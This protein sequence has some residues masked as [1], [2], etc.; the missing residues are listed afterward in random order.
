[1]GVD[2][3]LRL[4][5]PEGKAPPNQ[6]VLE[7]VGRFDVFPEQRLLEW[8]RAHGYIDLGSP[9]DAGRPRVAA[10]V[11]AVPPADESEALT[12]AEVQQQCPDVG[13]AYLYQALAGLVTAGDVCCRGKGQRGDPKRYW[14]PAPIDSS[15]TPR[16]YGRIVDR[17]SSTTVALNV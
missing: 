16:S 7:C 1:G 6:R 13:R 17:D 15:T 12:T 11:G 9:E 14:R 2:L 10:L 5:R 8:T 4:K 3:L